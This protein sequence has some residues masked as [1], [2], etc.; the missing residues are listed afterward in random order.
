MAQKDVIERLQDD[1][2]FIDATDDAIA[3]ITRLRAEVADLSNALET[4]SDE[5][6]YYVGCDY[7]IDWLI[8]GYSSPWEYA[9]ERLAEARKVTE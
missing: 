9:A 7:E 6:H 8:P 1:D 3:E 4:M 5:K 2:Q